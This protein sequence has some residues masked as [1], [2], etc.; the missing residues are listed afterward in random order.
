[1]S[2]DPP[3]NGSHSNGHS[4]KRFSFDG[5]PWVTLTSHSSETRCLY[6]P[7]SRRPAHPLVKA[8]LLAFN[9]LSAVAWG[10]LLYLTL[11]FIFTPRTALEKASNP[12]VTVLGQSAHGAAPLSW[13]AR[14]GDHLSGAYDFHGLGEATKY[15]Q[16]LAVMEVVHAAIGI[17]RSPVGTVASQVASRLWAV[18]GVVEMCP[19]VSTGRRLEGGGSEW[20][21]ALYEA[22]WFSILC[23]RRLVVCARNVDRTQQFPAPSTS[24]LAALSLTCRRTR[25]PCSRP[26]SS[27]GL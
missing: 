11:C 2:S 15:V 18:W 17:V 16:T 24:F 3:S 12:R 25:T 13:L 20:V 22:V 27:P 5:V 10:Y 14:L 4:R 26:C 19:S 23:R 1:M 7:P 8:Y 21:W 9:A 6:V